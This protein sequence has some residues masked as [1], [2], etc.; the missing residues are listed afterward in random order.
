[1]LA[2]P[3]VVFSLLASFQGNEEI[4]VNQTQG[5]SIERPGPEWRFRVA[6]GPG[7]ASFRLVITPGSKAT[8][9]VTVQ[10]TPVA[11]KTT[12]KHLVAAARAR[13]A[14]RPEYSDVE[15]LTR[16]IAGKTA[17]GI[18][19]RY[20]TS[21]ASF[22][23]QQ[24]YVIAGGNRYVL[25][26][27]ALSGEFAANRKRFDKALSSFRL[28]PVS[29]E[30]RRARRLRALAQKCGSEIEWAK[31]WKEAAQR[32]RN[33]S[34]LVLVSV[35][36]LSGFDII[37]A[38]QMGP[39]MDPDIIDLVRQRFV[40][41]RHEPGMPA[42]FVD[43]GSYGMSKTTFGRAILVVD[44]DG[45]VLAETSA[46]N[47]FA[48]YDF[49]V[50]SLAR[51]GSKPVAEPRARSAIDRAELALR[52]GELD[53]ASQLLQG[54]EG[55]HELRA[56]LYRRRRQGDRALAEIAGAIAAGSKSPS[57]ML[58]QASVLAGLGRID[59]ARAVLR[60]IIARH[61]AGPEV[62][63][64]QY[65]LGALSLCDGDVRRARAS[66]DRVIAAYGD[67][68]WSWLSAA[69]L[70]AMSKV[71][72]LKPRTQWPSEEALAEYRY[73][74][75]ETRRA[76]DLARVQRDATAY[77]LR[78]QRD[79]GSWAD[80]TELVLGRTVPPHPFSIAKAAIC[81]Q[82]LLERRADDPRHL[83]AALRALRFVLAA[84]AQERQKAAKPSFM[85]YTPW[86]KAYSLWFIAD[87]L[88]AGVGDTAALRAAARELVDELAARQKPGGGWSY[89]ITRTLADGYSPSTRSI[90]FTTATVVRALVAAKS[91]GIEVA[92]SLLGRG[93]DCLEAMRNQN[94]TFEYFM[95]P[96]P[97]PRPRATRRPGAAGRGPVC[98]LALFE[99]GRG[100]LDRLRGALGILMEHREALARQL[101]K[102]LM[103][104]GSDGQGCH[105]L[106]FDYA[107]AA[108]A[109]AYL[110]QAERSRYRPWLLDLV[111]AARATGGSF[112]DTELTGWAYGTAMA[113]RAFRALAQPQAKPPADGPV[114]LAGPADSGR[115]TLYL[116][117]EPIGRYEFDWNADGSYTGS[118]TLSIAGQSVTSSSKITVDKDG[119]WTE[120]TSQTP[121]GPGT[122]IRHGKKIDLE[123]LGKKHK[124]QA[125]PGEILY[126][127]DH[128]A[129]FRLLAAAYDAK[130]GG[131][132]KVPCLIIPGGR[133]TLSITKKPSVTRAVAGTDAKFSVYEVQIAT[134]TMSV[135]LDDKDHTCLILVPQQHAKIVRDGFEA[136]I[137][138]PIASDSLLSQPKFEITERRGEMVA[139]RDGVKLSTDIFL[140]KGASKSP[141]ILI[142][143]PYKKEMSELNARFYARRGYVAV[144]QDVR[145]R[146][147]SE[148]EWDPFVNEAKDGY[149]T[150]QWLGSR[151]YCDGKVGMIGGSYLGWVQWFAARERPSHLTTI[152]PNVS[153]PD[154][155]YNF[156]FEYGTFFMLGGIWWAEI[157]DKEATADLSGAAMAQ[158]QDRDYTKLLTSLPV[159]E[160][161]K[162]V[163]GK[164][165]RFWRKWTS[166]PMEDPYWR[167]ASFL[168]RLKDVR[169]PVFD[170]SGWFDGDGIGSKLNY[171]KMASYGHPYQKL[172]LGPWGHTDT[173]TRGVGPFDFGPRALRDLQTEYLRWFDKWLKGIAN[174]ID[175]EPLVSLFVMG[176]ND[177][178]EGNTYP[179]ESTQMQKWYLQSGGEANTS[180]GDG[181][182]S[183]TPPAADSA[184]DR[185]TYDPGDP[186]PAPGLPPKSDDDKGNAV[187]R[188]IRYHKRVIGE[189][190]DI[191]VYTSKP[192][193]KPLTIAGPI[194]AMLHASTSAKDTDWFMSMAK[195]DKDGKIWNLVTG[196]LR[197]RYR[198]WPAKPTLLEPGRVYA[199]KLDLWQ[200]GVTIEPGERLQV[201][202]ASARFPMFSR[203]LNTGGN[204]ETETKFVKAVQT[205]YHDAAHLSHVLLPVIP[206]KVVDAA[207]EHK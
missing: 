73:R 121:R 75:P 49:L 39:F 193:E 71:P 201:E 135:W 161:D 103:H 197:A 96:T 22:T 166:T 52:R 124:L 4:Y 111:L 192:F 62:A 45:H 127:D 60:E 157:V 76:S 42:P 104:A 122:L 74:A 114:S 180:G 130:A 89:Y 15:E 59:K 195:I 108:S 151:P 119:V 2:I 27:H 12:S 181:V 184:P 125:K 79:D 189:R 87:C 37:D 203:N 200:I 142:R 182:L 139:M 21:A 58:E 54:L 20:K 136:L 159:S 84:N 140:P 133:T 113:L 64:A 149:D 50:A 19:V 150:V 131:T 66:F 190:K 63:G 102:V 162:K 43:Q 115:F 95:A 183:A 98:E 120:I 141:A 13:V 30:A 160:L 40:A 191:L 92:K 31:T 206:P 198:E 70:I 145:G 6:S 100:S 32:A 26:C 29:A 25:Q 24:H 199:Y 53:R 46:V 128:P 81:G 176:P 169:I 5:F 196:K 138:K 65:W 88:S 172:V 202:V 9:Q 68:R 97:P 155:Y 118:R 44:A 3:L 137:K 23:I 69:T 91:A 56:S 194:S 186:T 179:L 116:N 38:Q 204:N 153:P 112:R 90:S 14:D 106:M 146:F 11:G 55:A 93:L 147:A 57:L 105:Y 78:S 16:S 33:E 185:F 18:R 67:S 107:T 175:K 72:E 164:V 170:Q 177:W 110:P 48:V 165:N 152:I 61:P 1:M 171:L 109:V 132:Q 163:F 7:A 82:S 8:P 167:R 148:G 17:H 47:R 173:A 205:V 123:I 99:G 34:R 77:L 85:D 174:G 156:P 144:V 126:G 158:I 35:W 41:F 178:L 80:G 168:D 86:S 207:F 154:A 51:L 83:D 10:V 117:E 134:I 129:L 143:T 94:G 188:A 36:R 28:L 187:T 101:G